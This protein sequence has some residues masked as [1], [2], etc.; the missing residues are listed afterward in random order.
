M[1]IHGVL[2]G[3]QWT[4]SVLERTF[5]WH[6]MFC[7][8]INGLLKILLKFGIDNSE[9]RSCTLRSR[10]LVDEDVSSSRSSRSATFNRQIRDW[11]PEWYNTFKNKDALIYSEIIWNGSLYKVITYFERYIELMHAWNV[12]LLCHK[13]VLSKTT[14]ANYVYFPQ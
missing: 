5:L 4:M 9:Q 13:S 11:F 6:G 10:K 2:L 12:F 7:W 3:L 8:F 14:M 1:D